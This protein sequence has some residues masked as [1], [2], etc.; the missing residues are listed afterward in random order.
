M[1]SKNNLTSNKRVTIGV[2]LSILG[3]LVL[4]VSIQSE[5]SELDSVR[6]EPLKVVTPVAKTSATEPVVVSK[7]EEALKVV[8]NPKSNVEIA[9][10]LAAFSDS[11]RKVFV[12]D[13]EKKARQNRYQNQAILNDVVRLIKTPVKSEVDRRNQD[14]AAEFMVAAMEANSDAAYAS[15]LDVMKD[16]MFEDSTLPSD[17]REQLAG[18][19]GEVIY[20]YLAYRPQDKTT[21]KS[22]LTGP[23]GQKIY[24]NSMQ[25]QNANLTE[26]ETELASQK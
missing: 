26:S 14:L 8:D 9:V 22:I 10:I 15:A 24:E 20:H 18:V 2:T 4:A 13:E 17:Q 23:V 5:K 1:N 19:A 3:F 25:L 6:S 11:Q 21:V 7:K 16:A 12:S